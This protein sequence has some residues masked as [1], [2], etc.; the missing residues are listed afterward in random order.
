MS[1]IEEFYNIGGI[2]MPILAITDLMQCMF[3]GV[4]P[5]AV[6]EGVAPKDAEP[7]FKTYSTQTVQNIMFGAVET[8]RFLVQL[9]EDWRHHPDNKKK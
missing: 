6:P 7:M 5:D 8:M 9:G 1:T 2:E 3:T 4:D